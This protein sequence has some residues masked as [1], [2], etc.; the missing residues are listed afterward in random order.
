MDGGNFCRVVVLPFEK[1]YK[2]WLDVDTIKDLKEAKVRV[3]I[4]PQIKPED[5]PPT[6]RSISSESPAESPISPFRDTFEISKG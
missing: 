6:N 1:D 3:S 4:S 5:T 2:Q